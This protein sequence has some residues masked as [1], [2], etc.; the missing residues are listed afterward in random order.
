MKQIILAGLMLV[1]FS[2]SAQKIIRS[3]KVTD[4][5][6]HIIGNNFEGVMFDKAYKAEY[7]NLI[8]K[9]PDRFSP[10]IAEV[11]LAEKLMQK[12]IKEIDEHSLYPKHGYGP[13]VHKHLRSYVRQ[14]LG[15]VNE[16]GEK[17]IY[18]NS[19][20]KKDTVKESDWLKDYYYVFDGG[21]AYWNVRV[22]LSTGELFGF[23]THGVA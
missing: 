5:S 11:L 14:Y 12:G 1:S 23:G 4:Q 3:E 20:W 16:K 10:S 15:F 9:Y 17:V 21:S 7:L 8:E 6:V 19:L 22:N 18:I 2:V 13:I